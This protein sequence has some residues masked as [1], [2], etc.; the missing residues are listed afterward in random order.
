MYFDLISYALFN[1]FAK[2]IIMKTYDQNHFQHY[3][4]RNITNYIKQNISY[5]QE[6]QFNVLVTINKNIH[7]IKPNLYILYHYHD[8]KISCIYFS[9]TYN[10]DKLNKEIEEWHDTFAI[11]SNINNNTWI[12]MHGKN[13]Q[14]QHYCINNFRTFDN[15]FFEQKS[16]FVNFLTL[17][18]K[19]TDKLKLQ[20][21]TL[22][23]NLLLYGVPGCGKSSFI[24]ALANYLHRNIYYINI[25]SYKSKD[26]FIQSL[27]QHSSYIFIF[28]DFDNQLNEL[29][30]NKHNNTN[31]NNFFNSTYTV[32]I[33]DL[34]QLF[35][36]V[37]TTSANKNDIFPIIIM[38]TNYL[39][40]I[41]SRI[42]RDGRM[43]YKIHF[44]KAS[45]KIIQEMYEY[46]YSESIKEDELEKIPDKYWTCATISTKYLK[47][48]DDQKS[49]I[50]S[51]Q[52][53]T[54]E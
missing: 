45:R 26:D 42:L 50:N 1:I 19:N 25:F 39:D 6:I 30:E 8:S 16:E 31:T 46:Y 22:K 40:K 38:T 17:F 10:Y 15:I 37:Y 51:L 44:E 33:D 18:K 35:D 9:F 12:F 54:E 14:S 4:V 48:I 32:S 49:F 29:S 21:M 53:I 7:K 5:S 24:K 28:E 52:T 23:L 11:T 2:S 36:G 3:E 41:D 20:G 27:T 47:Y 34:M 13:N 43:D